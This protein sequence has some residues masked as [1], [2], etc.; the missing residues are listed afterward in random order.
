MIDD[1]SGPEV[2]TV[3]PT[4]ADGLFYERIELGAVGD[5]HLLGIPFDLAAGSHRHHAKAGGLSEWCGVVEVGTGLGPV[6][7]DGIDP[8]SDRAVRFDAGIL[9]FGKTGFLESDHLFFA[10][11]AGIVGAVIEEGCFLVADEETARIGDFAPGPV[12]GC[13]G[14]VFAVVPIHGARLLSAAF[15]KFPLHHA[16][17]SGDA[18]WNIGLADKLG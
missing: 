12:L 11:E 14:T 13:L 10:G 6:T 1:G 15:F 2:F 3:F 8:F 18:V 17:L 16:G 5:F 7:L 9:L 4:F